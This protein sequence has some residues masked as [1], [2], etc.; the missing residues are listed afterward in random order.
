VGDVALIE[1]G[2]IIPCD[3]VFL[4]GHNVKCDE[5]AAT[6]ESDVIKKLSFEEC[7]DI[8]S[9]DDA[10]LTHTDCFVLSGSKALEGVGR[11]VVVAV[12]ASS[13]TGRIRM[14]LSPYL[15]VSQVVSLTMKI[16]HCGEAEDPP[17]QLKLNDLAELTAKIGSIAGLLFFLA[18]LI[19]FCVRLA[20]D[21]FR[22]VFPLFWRIETNGPHV[23]FYPQNF[24]PG[25]E[26]VRRNTHYLSDIRR[27]RC[28]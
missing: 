23:S 19:K 7:M 22:Y 16:A 25:G 8:S 21:G 20:R 27:L 17:L 9:R 4:S 1:P 14:G 28:S 15:N 11:Y 3:G 24:H 26:L 10:R 2:D 12:G 18:L 6:G 13:F 5:S